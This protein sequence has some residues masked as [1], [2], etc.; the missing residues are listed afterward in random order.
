MVV[1]ALLLSKPFPSDMGM[2]EAEPPLWRNRLSR[3][4]SEVSFEKYGG[5]LKEGVM[6]GGG[7]LKEALLHGSICFIFYLSGFLASSSW[8]PWAA[9]W[10]SAARSAHMAARGSRLAHPRSNSG[11]SP[12]AEESD[13]EEEEEELARGPWDLAC[14]ESETGPAPPQ[15]PWPAP[16]LPWA[17]PPPVLLHEG[18]P[19][20]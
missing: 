5:V 7:A 6:W 10:A 14:A 9:P 11:H 8:A 3:Q 2:S 19:S 20:R 4:Y 13:T 15:P 18:S 16:S 17:P 12:A 1:R